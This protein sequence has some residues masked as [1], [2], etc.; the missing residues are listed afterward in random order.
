MKFFVLHP[1]IGFDAETSYEPVGEVRL[2]EAPR[3][4]KCGIYVG[5][6]RWL[7]PYVVR[8]QAFGARIGDVAF[9]LA[10]G[11]LVISDRFV[12]AWRS[13]GL[14][15]LEEIDP[16]VVVATR[17]GAKGETG[18]SFF[19]AV[20]PRTESRID[21]SRSKIV[22]QGQ[23]TCDLC[24]GTSV[25]DAI[26]GLCIDESSW[27]GEDL[28]A[29][30]G[31]NGITVVTERVPSLASEHGLKNVTATPIESFHWDPLATRRG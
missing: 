18:R 29:P 11:D 4:P 14:H 5:M 10:G 2:G 23:A 22:R 16:V 12:T 19:H 26:Q 27:K 7:P 15:G 20:A 24:G 28:F 8:L 6:R 25:V 30:W 13:S 17:H 21:Y 3:C 31:V 1:W 9:D